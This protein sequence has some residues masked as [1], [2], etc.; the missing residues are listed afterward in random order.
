MAIVLGLA[1]SAGADTYSVYSCKGPTGAPND[2][3]GWAMAP[4]PSGEGRA[5]NA[6]P[7]QG[8]LSVYLDAAT[9]GGNASGTWTFAAPAD[10]RIVRFAARRRTVGVTHG[11][12][13]NDVQY[14]LATDQGTL[15]SCSI[16]DTSSCVAD[17]VEPIDK[18]GLDAAWVQFRVL[19]TDAGSFCTRPLR[20]DFGNVIVGLKDTSAPTVANVATID[21]GE[22]SGVLAARFDA[23]D[24]GGGLYRAVVKVDGKPAAT[25]PL[26]DAGCADANPADGDPYEFLAPVP[27]PATAAGVQVKVDYR[28]LSAGPHGIEIAVEDAAGNETSVFGP[29]QFPR[30]N[31][32]T[33]A[34][35]PSAV[36]RLVYAKLTMY[37]AEGRHKS[38]T[39]RYGRRVV[40]R[41]YLRD[42]NGKGIRGARIDVFH[43]IRGGGKRLLKTGLKTREGG[44]VTLILPLNV[45][46]RTIEYDYRA[47][48]PG[49]VTSSQ[50]LRLTVMR[51]G[52]RFVRTAG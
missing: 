40:T 28:S 31:A 14:V 45:D 10:T 4:A 48:R 5:T 50:R 34:S 44:K 30:P 43:V 3:A 7:A 42:R 19:C 27:C 13:A 36:Q 8:P 39:S 35:T 11:T 32:E 15:E 29:L 47:L 1:A 2:A 22:T 49:K 12:Q 26:G 52:R 6:C 33:P 46:T 23:A 41:G 21:D 51:H 17:L 37:F 24:R 25:Q 20:A 16:S 18:Q 38:Y 9:P